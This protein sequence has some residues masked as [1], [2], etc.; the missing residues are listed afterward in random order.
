MKKAVPALNEEG[1]QRRLRSGN[2]RLVVLERQTESGDDRAL[3]LVNHRAQIARDRARIWSRQAGLKPVCAAVCA[4]VEPLGVRVLRAGVRGKRAPGRMHPLWQPEAR[5][6]IEE[7]YPELDGGRYPVKR[8]V[9]DDFRGLG[10]SVSRRARQAARRRQ[11]PARGRTWREAPLIFF[12]NDRWVGRFR[13]DRVGLWRYTI[14]AWTDQFE[15]WRDEFEKK[16]EAGQDIALELVEGRA[17]VEAVL[18]QSEAAIAPCQSAQIAAGFRA[19]QHRPPHRAAALAGAARADGALAAAHRPGPL[20]ARAGDRR[21][22]QGGALC[23]LV[24]DVPAQP[25]EGARQE[26]HLR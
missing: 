13:L 20:S 25:G 1:P 21:R 3:I 14:E 5:I 4:I 6:E 10:R 8:I 22:P 24:R 26:R 12:D 7:V 15:S 23:R 2:D 11:I 16:R 18:A 17:I 9:G 19:R